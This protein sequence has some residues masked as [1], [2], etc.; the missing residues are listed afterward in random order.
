LGDSWRT[1]DEKKCHMH[2]E[3]LKKIAIWA[4]A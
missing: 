1:N 2:L 3:R 4:A